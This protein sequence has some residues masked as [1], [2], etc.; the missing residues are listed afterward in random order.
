MQSE[1]S[2]RAR[3]RSSTVY[4]TSVS[5]RYRVNDERRLGHQVSLWNPTAAGGRQDALNFI[6]NHPVGSA[7]EVYYDPQRPERAVLQPGA[8][9]FQHRL[10]C[11]GGV[12]VLMIAVLGL[13]RHK[14]I[15]APA[16][17]SQPQA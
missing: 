12:I 2:S 13:L 1:L 11:W 14:A 6:T 4:F 7:V 16:E 10:F 17:R 3:A 5:Y 15:K 8:D 9:E